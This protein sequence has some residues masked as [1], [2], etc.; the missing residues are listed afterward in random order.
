MT[1]KEEED[2]ATNEGLDK[3]VVQQLREYYAFMVRMIQKT[4]YFQ[5]Y[6]LQMRVKKN[7][8]N[9]RKRKD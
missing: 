1:K 7:G 4:G 5:Y 3:A 6:N 8:D 2:S 9:T